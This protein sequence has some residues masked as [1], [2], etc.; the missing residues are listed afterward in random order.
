[1]KMMLQN[2]DYVHRSGFFDK[3]A[4]SILPERAK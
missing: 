3:E 1:M 2:E 4:M